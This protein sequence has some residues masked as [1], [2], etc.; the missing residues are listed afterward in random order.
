MKVCFILFFILYIVMGDWEDGYPAY[1]HYP[2]RYPSSASRYPDPA[3][4][5]GYVAGP[6]S[7]PAPA[8]STT[9]APDPLP[10]PVVVLPVNS[11]TTAHTWGKKC[12]SKYF[13]K[14]KN[15]LFWSN[16][17]ITSGS[18]HALISGTFLPFL[19]S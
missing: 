17:K 11:T 16:F 9:P 5:R 7:L 12:H 3:P 14:V 18:K 4:E 2:E 13:Q 10:I 8:S 1:P 6:K 15:I 19:S